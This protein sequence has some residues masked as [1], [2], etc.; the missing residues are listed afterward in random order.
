MVPPSSSIQIDIRKHSTATLISVIGYGWRF[1]NYNK[2]I[3]ILIGSIING[4]KLFRVP[5][6]AQKWEPCII[7]NRTLLLTKERP[8]LKCVHV[9]DMLDMFSANFYE[10]SVIDLTI[11]PANG[12]T[13]LTIINH[14]IQHNFLV[15]LD[16]NK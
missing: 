1:L 11:T 4:D 15:L 7:L 16:G 13:I 9:G 8:I 14:L 2:N 3:Y 6:C 12:V 10:R 5:T